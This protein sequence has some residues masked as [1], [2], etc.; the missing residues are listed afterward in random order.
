M[1]IRL[2]PAVVPAAFVASVASAAAAV[3]IPIPDIIKKSTVVNPPGSPIQMSQCYG[4]P[5]G[6]SL[7]NR[8]GW[9]VGVRFVNVQDAPLKEVSI[10]FDGQDESGAVLGSVEY[11]LMGSFAKNAT[12]D[13]WKHFDTDNMQT[14]AKVRC[15]VLSATSQDGS[16]WN[17]PAPAASA[18]PAPGGSPS[19]VPTPS[20][21]SSPTSAPTPRGLKP[22]K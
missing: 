19:A 6:A 17:A 22:R 2:M 9:R 5:F 1:R 16:V 12:I 10:R 20:P 4:Y 18:T 14:V 3:L 21:A 13:R 11:V 15:A 7:A 8:N